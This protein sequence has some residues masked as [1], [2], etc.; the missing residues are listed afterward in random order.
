MVFLCPGCLRT[1]ALHGQVVMTLPRGTPG[2]PASACPP[3]GPREMGAI[4]TD[5]QSLSSPLLLLVVW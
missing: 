3:L 2:L 5:L 4:Q 1:Y